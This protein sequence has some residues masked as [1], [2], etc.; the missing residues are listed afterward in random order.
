MIIKKK[1]N[2]YL[3][4]WKLISSPPAPTHTLSKHGLEIWEICLYDTLF[5]QNCQYI[6]HKTSVAALWYEIYRQGIG[7][8]MYSG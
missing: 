6:L 7:Y 3:N 4:I 5:F 1:I 8:C 2:F